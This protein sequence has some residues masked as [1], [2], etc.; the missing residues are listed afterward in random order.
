MQPPRRGVCRLGGGAFFLNGQVCNGPCGK[1]LVVG[2]FV[3][4][5]SKLKADAGAAFLRGTAH[6][7]QFSLGVQQFAAQ[8]FGHRIAD[9]LGAAQALHP[10]KRFGTGADQR[11]RSHTKH[12]EQRHTHHQLHQRGAAPGGAA[13]KPPGAAGGAAG[14]ETMLQEPPPPSCG[15][16]NWRKVSVC[17]ASPPPTVTVTVPGCAVTVN[18]PAPLNRYT[19]SPSGSGTGAAALP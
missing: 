15:G 6:K 2:G 8:V 13:G 14:A 11:H 4:P 12:R 1:F 3:Q 9:H 7:A 17:S 16:I 10:G 5:G 19:A 18:S